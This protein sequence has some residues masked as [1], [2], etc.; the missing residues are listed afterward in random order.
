MAAKLRAIITTIFLWK[1][2]LLL[3][4]M[5]TQIPETCNPVKKMNSEYQACQAEL[6]AVQ[7]MRSTASVNVDSSHV[8]ELKM[9][10]NVLI[11]DN[12]DLETDYEE[13]LAIL[14][15]ELEALKIKKQTVSVKMTS[16]ETNV[17]SLLSN[18]DQLKRE[19]DT[20]TQRNGRI[21]LEIEE[22]RK[23]N[24]SLKEMCNDGNSKDP[25]DIIIGSGNDVDR[26]T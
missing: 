8:T 18:N 4:M 21:R 9:N 12:S 7:R 14:R 20:Y 16:I 1:S 19:A 23:M 3:T 2:T 25:G 17:K 13:K 5:H 10:I 6:L 15:D 26:F 11:N 22:V 24:R